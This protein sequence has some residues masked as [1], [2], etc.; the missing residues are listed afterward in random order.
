MPCVHRL[1]MTGAYDED[2]READAIWDRVDATMDERRRERREAR[3]KEELERYRR[4]NPKI[5]EQFADLKRGLAEVSEADWEAIP[6]I[7]D[8]SVKKQKRFESF[9]PPPDSLLAKAIAEKETVSHVDPNGLATPSGTRTVDLNSVGEGRGTVLS[10]KL[11]RMAD[12][13][14]G[15]TVVDPKGY[16]TDLKGMK[17]TSSAEISDIKKARLL[18]K[19]VIQTNPKHGPGWIAA[20]RL[21]EVAGKIP[22]ARQLLHRG[23]EEC[24]GSEDVW[25]EAARLQTP[26]NAKAILA[27]GVMSLP[28]S[29]RLWLQAARLE[30]DDASKARVIRKALENVPSSVRLWKAAVDLANEDDARTLLSR[31][32]ECC[33]EH[34]ELWL[35]LAKLEDYKSARAVLNRARQ[36]VPT[37][38][39]IWITAAKLEEAHGNVAMVEKLIERSLRDLQRHNVIIDR[40]AWLK[41]A[42]TTEKSGSP[43]TCRAIVKYTVGIGIEEADRK[44][45]WMADADESR[46]RGCLETARAIFSHTLLVF[47]GKKSV[48]IKAAELEK[49]AGDFKALDA[50]LQRAVAACPNAEVLWL[51]GA[52]E[53]WLQGDVQGAREILQLA[54]DANP[55]SDEIYLAAFKLEFENGELERARIILRRAREKVGGERV[56]MK[57]AIIERE[58]GDA[59]AELQLLKE[60]LKRHPD[61]WKMIL[62]LG[63]LHYRQARP[64]HARDAYAR[65][66][67]EC[68]T[69][70]HLWIA[71]A[72]L[73][74]Q[75]GNMSK[76]RALMEQARHRNPKQDLLWLHAIRMEACAAGGAK[77]AESLMAKA[78]QE[79]PTSGRLWAQYIR[80][81]S[82]PQKK[83]RSVDA[84]K[85]CNNDASVVTAV[86]M[87][88][89]SERKID[90]ARSWFNRAVKLAPDNGDI[91][92]AAYRFE[93]SQGSTEAADA[94]KNACVASD[95]RHGEVWSATRKTVLNWHESTSSVLEK[96]AAEQSRLERD[97]ALAAASGSSL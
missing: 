29:V 35:A 20:A 37:D 11:D 47:P 48:W 94:L 25:L 90:K 64:G 56:W 32:V 79:C 92:A 50:L 60:G 4:E 72:M 73:D 66:I 15:Q 5:T 82:R 14:T 70:L 30:E 80:M 75:A 28:N 52:K 42:E 9:A 41:D 12:S 76:A 74:E 81:A 91:W 21:E 78:L 33:P 55:D 77:V 49:Q 93:K 97:D 54:F 95:P 46:L 84:L 61:C 19:S 39:Q 86:A 23:V 17:I 85:R 58:A 38:A 36:A 13:V 87:L 24:P 2:D 3:E 1:G 59:D 22:A 63:Q 57:S 31:A 44:R 51:M 83:A 26:D 67:R 34:V 68:P 65:G 18:L 43:A 69:C 6:E 7:G 96:V 71:A 27:R 8:Y 40:D 88:F 10:M 16:L 53:R 45:T 62:M 89:W